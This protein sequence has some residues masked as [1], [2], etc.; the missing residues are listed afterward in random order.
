MEGGH[1]TSRLGKKC[2]SPSQPG[3]RKQWM[4]DHKKANLI[5]SHQHCWDD[6]WHLYHSTW[7]T[8]YRSGKNHKQGCSQVGTSIAVLQCFLGCCVTNLPLQW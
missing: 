1:S 2:Y 6:W 8:P 7:Y 5:F 3:K 4:G